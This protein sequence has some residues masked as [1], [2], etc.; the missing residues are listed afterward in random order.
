MYRNNAKRWTVISLLITMA[1]I[2]MIFLGIIISDPGYYW[3]IYVGAIVTLAFLISSANFIRQAGRLERLFDGKELLAHWVFGQAER[4]KRAETELAEKRARHT[5]MLIVIGAFFLIITVIFLL[6]G[7]DDFEEALMFAGIM[8]G[9]FAVIAASALITPY[10]FYNRMRSSVPEV[11]IGP[12]SVWV[13]GEYTQWKA[14]MTKITSVSLLSEDS[15]SV[16]EIGYFILQRYGPQP[17]TLR[18]PVPEGKEEEAARISENL[19]AINDVLFNK[20]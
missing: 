4:L 19:A 7:F 8:V 1:G 2:L 6:F 5:V 14:P 15:G 9:V 18:I 10:V 11:F 20:L 16:I 17:H 12:Y 3:M 13:M